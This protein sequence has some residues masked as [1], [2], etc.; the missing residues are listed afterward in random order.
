MQ[1][2]GVLRTQRR[3]DIA[4]ETAFAVEVEALNGQLNKN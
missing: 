1:V 4:L 2:P 3:V